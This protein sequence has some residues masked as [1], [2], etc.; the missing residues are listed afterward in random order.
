MDGN[1]DRLVENAVREMVAKEEE[2][3]K[4]VAEKSILQLENI[5]LLF[6]LNF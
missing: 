4:R 6:N 2:S 1:K 5:Y 3:S